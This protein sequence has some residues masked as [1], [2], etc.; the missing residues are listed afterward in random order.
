MSKFSHDADNDAAADDARALTIPRRF[1]FENSRA[2]KF[3]F[4]PYKSL[5][6]QV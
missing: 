6:D 4:F 3:H 5:S 2:K 1:F